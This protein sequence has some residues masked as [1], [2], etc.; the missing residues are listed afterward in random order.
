M[1]PRA[2]VLLALCAVV[3]AHAHEESPPANDESAPVVRSVSGVFRGSWMASR[4]GRRFQAY[5]GIRYAEPPV[6]E[7]RFQPPKLKLQYSGEVNASE[8][9]P[10]CPQ[11]LPASS[12]MDEDCLTVNVYTPHTNSSEQLPVIFYIHAGGFYSMSGR[13]DFAGPHYLLERD[14]VLVTINYRIGALGWISTGDAFAPGNNGMKDQVAALKWVQRNIAAF[15]GDP[16]S[17][18]ITGC[19]AGSVSV[20][21]HMVSPM[22]KGLFHRAISISAS[23]ISKAPMVTHQRHLAVLQAQILKCPTDNT[24]VIYDCLMKKPWKDFGDS[25]PQFW[26]LGPS[27]P[28]GLW[29]PVVE[30]DVGQER[31]LS[32]DPLAAIQHGRLHTVPYIISQT[33]DEYFGKSFPLFLQNAA[34]QEPID[35]ESK[36]IAPISF[37]LPPE[38]RSTAME[39]LRELYLHNK[40]LGND[41]EGKKALG[42]FYGDTVIGFGVHRLANLMCRHSKHPVWYYEFAY[43]GNNS[44]Y[45]DPDGKPQAAVHFDDLLYLFTLSYAF[46][47][48]PLSS[49]DSHVVDE[50]TAMWYNFAR[51]GD[52][53]P[54]A[55]TPELS[56][57][58]WPAMTPRQRNYLRRGDQLTVHQNMF[59]DRFKVWDELYP[60]DY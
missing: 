23:P 1:L 42:R 48:I 49:K 51:Y 60:I 19:S 3:C 44:H 30:P 13:S 15:G 40:T 4:R 31:Y 27:N 47:T 35:E 12:Y 11:P 34:N 14:V 9:G 20:L 33:T 7:L 32:E 5:R 22:T 2:C 53:N 24:S 29:M 36:R 25:L 8:E 37:L 21:L 38:N 59:E 55:D 10:A 56:A 6:G 57:L 46:P 17:V 50:M 28:A 43:V 39:R 54:R 45:Q 26:L 18:T 41:L 16:N 58:S 52:P